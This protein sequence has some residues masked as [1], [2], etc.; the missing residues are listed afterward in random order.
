MAMK[1]WF[2]KIF[3]KKFW[4]KR[5]LIGGGIVLVAVI[6]TVVGLCT[7]KRPDT[8]QMAL[9]NIAEARFY[10]KAA[11]ADN[12]I[13]TVQLSSGLRESDFQADGI[14]TPTKA[15]TVLSVEPK[16]Q[17]VV[18]NGCITTE[19]QLGDEAPVTLVLEK[20][21]YGN[22]YA[23][24]L[25]KAVDVNTPVTITFKANQQTVGVT[26]LQNVMPEGAIGWEKAL[27]IACQNLQ[28]HLSTETRVETSTK[29]LCDNT[30]VNTPYWFVSFVS[31]SGDRSFV[32]V[33]AQGNVVGNSEKK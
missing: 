24:D 12:P 4:N 10:L 5:V 30:T 26:Q 22:N 13:G 33:D 1:T 17:Q 3:S 20:N 2:K 21:P 28:G 31:E 11:A 27:E 7:V 14:A 32:V 8:Y 29:I 15:F 16:D 18:F 25:E 9:D 23:A 6:I 19:V